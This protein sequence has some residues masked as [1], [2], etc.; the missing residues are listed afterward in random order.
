MSMILSYLHDLY[1]TLQEFCAFVQVDRL[2]KYECQEQEFL[3]RLVR[4]Y[5][6]V[7]VHLVVSGHSLSSK[8]Y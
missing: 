3:I 6:P 8:L 1:I 2:P 5:Q 7:S 4:G